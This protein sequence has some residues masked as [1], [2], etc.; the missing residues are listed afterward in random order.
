MGSLH[1]QII[2]AVAV[3]HIPSGDHICKLQCF[4]SGWQS[5]EVSRSHAVPNATW[6]SQWGKCFASFYVP[7]LQ[8]TKAFKA[9]THM[10][11]G[12]LVKTTTKIAS[13][14]P[15]AQLTYLWNAMGADIPLFNPTQLWQ[16]S[17]RRTTWAPLNGLVHSYTIMLLAWGGTMPLTCLVWSFF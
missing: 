6:L 17:M 16:A 10:S 1:H 11:Q 2:G 3:P 4:L 15:T 14:Q 5:S 8:E 9:S 12:Q 13:W 7:G